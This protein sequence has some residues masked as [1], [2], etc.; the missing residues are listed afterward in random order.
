MN[1][2]I[3]L[4]KDRRGHWRW[5]LLKGT[6]IIADGAEGY[7]SRGNLN[8][9]IRTFQRLLGEEVPVDDGEEEA[10]PKKKRS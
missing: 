7:A 8:R 9:A 2:R 4:F 10:R 5:R 6:R 1:A 3:Q